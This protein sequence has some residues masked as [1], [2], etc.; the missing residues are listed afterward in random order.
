MKFIFLCLHFVR[1]TKQMKLHH[2]IFMAYTHYGWEF[3]F[4]A[5]PQD[6]LS[7][8]KEIWSSLGVIFNSVKRQEKSFTET[9]GIE[10]D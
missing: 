3:Y 1:K 8:C 4:L 5:S 10:D 6:F 7:L 2:C 9:G